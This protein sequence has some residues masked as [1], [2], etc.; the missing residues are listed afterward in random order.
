VEIQG[1]LFRLWRRKST[2]SLPLLVLTHW[3]YY[4]DVDLVYASNPPDSLDII[5]RSEDKIRHKSFMEFSRKCKRLSLLL[6][7]EFVEPLTNSETK[8]IALSRLGS[9]KNGPSDPSFLSSAESE[10]FFK[11]RNP[12]RPPEYDRSLPYALFSSREKFPFGFGFSVVKRKKNGGLI[13]PFRDLDLDKIC[14]PSN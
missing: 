5:E 8:E 3:S 9:L 10:V 11:I 14:P 7:F 2:A 13:S 4:A 1:K 6:R 12:L